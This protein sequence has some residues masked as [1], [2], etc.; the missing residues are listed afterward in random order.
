MPIPPPIDAADTFKT[1][2]ENYN[3]L[4][5]NVLSKD[6]YW[7]L[8]RTLPTIVT[9]YVNI[10]YWE[11]TDGAHSF[12]ID[13]VFSDVNFSIAKKYSFTTNKELINSL[14]YRV[15]PIYDT[16][17]SNGNNFDLEVNRS[18]N[19]TNIRI[20]R[21]AGSYAGTASLTVFA[22]EDSNPLSY[23]AN[24][25]TGGATTEVEDLPGRNF[26]LEG[27]IDGGIF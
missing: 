5:D 1:W 26:A 13:L 21:T 7:T 8:E 27:P 18:E 20:T 2:R 23:T 6:H 9:Q 15:E 10:G 4:L 22:G 24:S 25:G 17:E 12:S 19:K 3:E 16:G 14:W 11:R